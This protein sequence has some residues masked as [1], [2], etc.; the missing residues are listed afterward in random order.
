[1][2]LID[3]EHVALFEI[4][5][6]GREIAGLG[7]DWPRRGAKIDAELARHDLGERRLAEARRPGEE[8][9]V[10]SFV[11]ALRRFDEHLQVL[12]DLRLPDEFLEQLRPEM[13][14]ELVLGAQVA[15]YETVTHA[16]ANSL[17]PSRMSF[18]VVASSPAL[19][20]AALTATP[21]WVWP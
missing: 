20:I 8:H 7:D 19:R 11:A 6:K 21:A 2:D 12:L 5:E 10:K 4:G 17:R 9:V 15:V 14:V 3:E 18:S 1:M 16:T 13:R